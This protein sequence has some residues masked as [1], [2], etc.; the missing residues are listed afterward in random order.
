MH[1]N[2]PLRSP[3]RRPRVV[4]ALVVAVLGTMASVPMAVLAPSPVAAAVCGPAPAGRIAVA[5][6]VDDGTGVSTRCAEVPERSNG[7]DA[8]V[9]A[10]HVLRI[11]SGFLCAIDGV[12]ATGCG[13]RPD[14]AGAYWRYFHADP[15]GPWRYST[16]GGGG[17]RLPARCAIEGW[18]WS[19]QPSTAVTP[20]IA[21]PPVR[22][23]L[24]APPTTR[25][26]TTRPPAT[27]AAPAPPRA[28]APG[29]VVA[30]GSAAPSSAA[31][32][33]PAPGAPPVDSQSTT[34]A[35]GAEAP[36]PGGATDE[37][38]DASSVDPSGVD[39]QQSSAS[40]DAVPA[41]A[42][43]EHQASRSASDRPE[44]LAA[45]QRADV[46]G[47]RGS[48]TGLVVALALATVLGAAAL[49][50]SRR[51]RLPD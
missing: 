29:P 42:G 49:W 25:P 36:E 4:T 27:T 13:N 18:R 41:D 7:Y 24:P 16:V 32:G 44:V 11:E 22:C 8:L 21:P 38:D 15:G 9:A 17:Y 35:P 30:G 39:P 28:P 12:P 48:P 26:P 45:T 50:R 40:G 19:D 43:R 34:T 6:V 51:S 33:A 2:A 1:L 37:T 23:E 5:V 47:S 20:R 3:R 46:S 10:G 31:P 14:F